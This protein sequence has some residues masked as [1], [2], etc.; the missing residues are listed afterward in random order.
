M[1]DDD[2]LTRYLDAHQTPELNEESLKTLIKEKKLESE[3]ILSRLDDEL[4]LLKVQNLHQPLFHIV[5]QELGQLITDDTHREILLSISSGEPI[6][7]VAV[8]HQMTY[9]ETTAVYSSIL[10]QLG[11]NT[12]RIATYRNRVLKF[13]YGKYDIDDPTNIPLTRLMGDQ[14]RNLLYKLNILTVRQL[15]QYTSQKGWPSLKRIEGMGEMTYNEIINSLY[16]ANFIILHENK[17]IE[18][19]PEIA[20]LVL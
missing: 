12:A 9:Q 19:S 3:S 20:A 2:S 15:L 14:A 13:L 10:E 5:I 4:F 11:K 6:S 1:L 17:R 18:L 16:N 8:H 7:R